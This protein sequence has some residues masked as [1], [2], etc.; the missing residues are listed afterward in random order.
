MLVQYRI[1]INTVIFKLNKMISDS[2]IIVNSKVSIE[3][4]LEKRDL[5]IYWNTKKNKHQLKF[6]AKDDIITYSNLEDYVIRTYK[7][8]K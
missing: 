7:T 4:D 2:L 1:N 3:I 8:I 6:L 5:E